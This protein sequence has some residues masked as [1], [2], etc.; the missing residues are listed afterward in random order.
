MQQSWQ[1]G[2]LRPK[3]T[4]GLRPPDAAESQLE[5]LRKLEL[6][7]EWHWE[8]QQRAHARGI[9]FL[10]TAFDF[11]SL[12]FW[13]HSTCLLQRFR[14]GTHHRN[15]FFGVRATGRPLVV[16]TGMATLSEVN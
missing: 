15:H 1:N 13:R 8:L 14:R 5:M 7:R 3:Q 9:E 11:D 12:T 2:W 4:I 10:S 16:S 6:P